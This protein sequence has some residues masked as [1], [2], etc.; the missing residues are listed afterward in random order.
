LG[1]KFGI[2]SG[3]T[4][5]LVLVRTLW[6]GKKKKKIPTRLLKKIPP[7]DSP[8]SGSS[9]SGEGTFSGNTFFGDFLFFGEGSLPRWPTPG[10]GAS[11][12]R[13]L[14]IVFF[15]GGDCYPPQASFLRRSTIWGG[16]PLVFRGIFPFLKS[17]WTSAR[18]VFSSV[19]GGPFRAS[20]KKE[21]FPPRGF[22][23]G[24]LGKS[25]AC[26]KRAFFFHATGVFSLG[27]QSLSFPGLRGGPE[28]FILGEKRDNRK[29]KILGGF[30]GGKVKRLR[31]DF[32][33]KK[34]VLRV[35]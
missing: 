35:F 24:F 20:E 26:A 10:G 13:P 2:F 34:R 31:R 12:E 33:F 28:D 23:S 32:P 30:R 22:R 16:L 19:G 9:L 5:F 17:F 27:N 18:G 1:R 8:P 3:P 25:S 14:Q 6:G 15:L 7:T 29:G 11:G 4:I 21:I